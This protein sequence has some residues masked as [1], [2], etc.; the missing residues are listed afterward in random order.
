MLSAH[1]SPLAA[2]TVHGGPQAVYI[3]G[4]ARAL[5]AAG[6][7]VEVLTRRDALAL[8]DDVPMAPGVRVLHID[9]GP[10][11]S[12]SPENLL[13]WMP[14]FARQAQRRLQGGLAYD[15]IH[16]NFFLSGWV[17]LVLRPVLH[18]PLVTAL[19]G[20]GAVRREH[21]GT[22]DGFPEARETIEHTLAHRSDRVIALCP[23]ERSELVQRYGAASARIE[24]VPCG[25]DTRL[26]RPGARARARRRLGLPPEEF[27]VLQTGRIVADQSID[28]VVR[29][30]ALLPNSVRARLVIVGG[31][32]GMPD[33]QATPEIGALL[34]L[35][36]KSGL[37]G[38]ITFA[39]HCDRSALRYW[40]V[41][42][43]VFAATPWLDPF[44]M[45][46]LE[47]M[48]CATPVVGSCVG[49]IAY[50]VQQGVTGYLVPPQA[51]GLLAERLLQLALQPERARQLGLAGRARAQAH[52]T[53]DQAA[54]ELVQVFG[55]LHR[56]GGEERRE[57]PRR[58]APP[59]A[60]AGCFNAD[61]PPRDP[62]SRLHIP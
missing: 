50:V 4:M 46:P 37:E 22:A 28:N 7:A 2:G 36:A 58:R 13:R 20:L 5:G 31:E 15:A 17:G 8:P 54:Q 61:P 1:V 12:V 55:S 32:A 9:A 25:V 44:G 3:D 49:A 59:P 23:Q 6:H 52:F 39:D 53:W 26:F 29:A 57:T 10:A 24:M 14:A 45:G 51:P 30:L 33:P 40:Y 43:D 56:R 34:R 19:H 38:R 42:A 27:I 18:A 11:R 60:G 47:A 62:T 21:L 48:A 41:A 35:A 16:A